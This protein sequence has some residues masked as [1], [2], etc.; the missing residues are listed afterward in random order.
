LA[1]F[2]DLPEEIRSRAP[3]T[4]TYSLPQGQDEFY[5][6]LP[7]DKMDLC[8]YGKNHSIPVGDV[9]R[10]VGMTEEDVRF[11]YEDIDRKR[12]TTRSLHL[13]PLLVGPVPEVLR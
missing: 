4:D 10:A 1:E 11:V 6:S 13:P 8:L 9:A 7:Y 5:F 3:S 12:A 2:L